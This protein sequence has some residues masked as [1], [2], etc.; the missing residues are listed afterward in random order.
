MNYTSLIV[1]IIFLLLLFWTFGKIRP[2]LW[3][4]YQNPEFKATSKT[5]RVSKPWYYNVIVPIFVVFFIATMIGSVL[6]PIGIM[7]LR[8]HFFDVSS[9]RL[10]E[11]L[12]IIVLFIISIPFGIITP[13]F[14]LNTLS[15]L[16]FPKFIQYD[17][18]RNMRNARGV[19]EN[20][21]T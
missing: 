16:F 20:E 1:K 13:I 10:H 5:K 2:L 9:H 4:R 7:S 18:L 14:T 21:N 11:S 3:R 15:H 19:A 17:L 6:I 8:T 12:S